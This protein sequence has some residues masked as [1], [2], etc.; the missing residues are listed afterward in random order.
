MKTIREVLAESGISLSAATLKRLLSV[1]VERRKRD[2]FTSESNS[3][4][5]EGMA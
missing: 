3:A 1:E 4:G 2:R 5:E